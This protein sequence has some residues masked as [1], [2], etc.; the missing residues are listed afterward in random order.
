MLKKLIPTL[1]FALVILG[2]FVFAENQLAPAFQSCLSQEISER[3]PDGVKSD[4]ELIRVEVESQ[5]VCSL[6][7]L[8]GHSG[9]F[10]AVAAFVI[11]LLTFTLWRASEI[12][13]RELKRSVDN[14]IAFESPMIFITSIVL[15]PELWG[16]EDT[17]LSLPSYKCNIVA[18]HENFGRSPAVILGVC[19]NW[20][21]CPELPAKPVYDNI[22]PMAS[23]TVVRP[24]GKDGFDWDRHFNVQF[25]PGEIFAETRGTTHLW[26]YGFVLYRGAVGSIQRARFCARWVRGDRGGGPYSFVEDGPAQYRGH[27]QE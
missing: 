20:K 15:E 18:Y 8:D 24:N 19:L 25:S 5:A 9:F 7:L 23:G 13:A 12:Q 27:T 14:S 17:W 11:A 22:R 4:G 3:T 10:A 26:V 21:V 2:L 1:L 6:R 16:S